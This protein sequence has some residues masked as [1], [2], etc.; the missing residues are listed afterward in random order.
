ML[1]LSIQCNTTD[2]T[3]V[4]EISVLAV[5]PKRQR[6]LEFVAERLAEVVIDRG[7][8]VAGDDHRCPRCVAKHEM[9]RLDRAT[10][11]GM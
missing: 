7:W 1:V 4:V 3:A 5:D 11:L 2:C 10:A 9:S 6:G 8:A